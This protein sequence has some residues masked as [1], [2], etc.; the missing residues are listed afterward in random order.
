MVRKVWVCK[1]E[2]ILRAFETLSGDRHR[3]AVVALD[4]V[5][6]DSCR[7]RGGLVKPKPSLSA[8]VHRHLGFLVHLLSFLQ[9][10][11][12]SFASGFISIDNSVNGY[13]D[14]VKYCQHIPTNPYHHLLLPQQARQLL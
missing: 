2:L 10:K 11:T 3:S 5:M 12:L 14:E 7:T 13:L 1:G 8:G 4:S 9:D 6:T